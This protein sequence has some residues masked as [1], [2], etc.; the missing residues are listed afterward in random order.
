MSIGETV[1]PN[2]AHGVI[3][4]SS[5]TSAMNQVRSQVGVMIAFSPVAS[6]CPL[7]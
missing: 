5:R 6:T 1:S 4:S 2:R 3:P 7:T